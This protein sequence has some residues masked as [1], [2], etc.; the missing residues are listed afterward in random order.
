MDHL[1]Q[2]TKIEQIMTWVQQQIEQ[3]VWVSGSKLPSVRAMAQQQHVSVSTIVEAY[4]RLAAQDVLEARQG[5]GYFVKSQSKPY[6]LVSQRPQLDREVDPLW[7]SRQSLDAQDDILKPGCGWLP[8]TWMP[9]EVVRKA[10]RTVARS[11]SNTLMNYATSL[12]LPELR[13][14]IS[15]RLEA[16]GVLANPDQVLLV[17]S[18][19]HA[20]DLICRLGLKPGDT[21]LIDD[22]CYFNFQALLN[23]HRVKTIAIPFTSTGPD[24]EAFEQALWHQPKFYITNSGVHNPTGASLSMHTAYQILKWAEQ[25]RLLIIEDDIWSDLELYPAPRYAALGGFSQV[26]QIGSFSKTVSASIRCGYIVANQD[27]ISPLIDLKIATTLSHDHF[28]TAV[29]TH[30]LN[31]GQYRKH[32]DWLRK[33]LAQAM[34]Y[35]LQQLSA[36]KIEPWILPKAGMLLWCKLPEGIDAARL[37][38]YCLAQGIIL[39]PGNAFSQSQQ[40]N[41][42][43]RFNVAQALHA[44]VYTVLAEGLKTNTCR[45][46]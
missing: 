34:T 4:A 46:R 1:S 15:R 39:A 38:Q 7:I 35:N 23:V 20:I 25:H 33:N 8:T 44:K 32:L 11:E 5:A 24:L 12:G 42:F 18:G 14:V 22:P 10:I 3:R 45:G 26:L 6:L 2:K 36:L 28:N 9:E 29:I 17:E 43:L 41:Q 13:Q 19:T 31:D 21:V 37:S 30:V 27:W 16:T 40:A